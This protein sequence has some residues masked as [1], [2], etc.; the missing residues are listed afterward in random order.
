MYD[1][2][3][4]LTRS[5]KIRDHD[6]VRSYRLI[7]RPGAALNETKSATPPHTGEL[8]LPTAKRHRSEV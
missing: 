8:D 5:Y 1:F 6:L 7:V 3:S 2:S 4:D